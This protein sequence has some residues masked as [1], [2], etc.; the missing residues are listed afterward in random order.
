MNIISISYEYRY[1]KWHISAA[2]WVVISIYGL[3]YLRVH[4]SL[5]AGQEV[6]AS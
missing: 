1:L 5:L 2:A 3:G 6:L 4:A